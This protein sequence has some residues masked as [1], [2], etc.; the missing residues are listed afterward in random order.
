M[1]RKSGAGGAAMM[2]ALALAGCAAQTPEEYNAGRGA[3]IGGTT[4]ALAALDGVAS[5]IALLVDEGALLDIWARHSRGEVGAFTMQLYTALGQRFFTE[6]R[7]RHAAD[8]DFRETVDRYVREFERL[9]IAA[10]RED[11]GDS[12][13][14]GL[15]AAATGKVY[16]LLAHAAGRLR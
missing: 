3:L 6:I 5:K 11:G 7:R 16:V 1:N 2:T 10:G 13:V 9:L 8:P 4:G 12:R 14:L 15:V